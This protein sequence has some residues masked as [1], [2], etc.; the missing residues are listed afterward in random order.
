[1]QTEPEIGITE[2]I[3]ESRIKTPL[4]RGPSV[5]TLQDRGKKIESQEAPLKYIPF[6]GKGQVLNPKYL[7]QIEEDVKNYG[8]DITKEQRLEQ[9]KSQ[10]KDDWIE[11]LEEKA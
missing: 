10:D 4:E 8:G 3:I 9:Y 6:Q 7:E 1:M 2:K 11:K 5:V